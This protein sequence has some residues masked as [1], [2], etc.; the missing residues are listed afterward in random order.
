[1]FV[2]ARRRRGARARAGCRNAG[3]CTWLPEAFYEG[4]KA[5]ELPLAEKTMNKGRQAPSQRT[6]ARRDAQRAPVCQRMLERTHQHPRDTGTEARQVDAPRSQDGRSIALDARRVFVRRPAPPRSILEISRQSPLET[7]SFNALSLH[8]FTR[9]PLPRALALPSTRVEETLPVE[10]RDFSSTDGTDTLFTRQSRSFRNP[11]GPGP[12]CESFV[13][14]L[15]FHILPVH[16]L[17]TS[18]S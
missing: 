14:T 10:I 18:T 6:N 7:R 11:T 13:V 12:P 9:L 3:A 8:P 5:Y 15:S 2:Q 4:M 17:H 1:M 16:S